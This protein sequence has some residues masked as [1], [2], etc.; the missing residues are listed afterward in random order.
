MPKNLYK[1]RNIFNK[2]IDDFIEEYPGIDNQ[3]FSGSNIK[4]I[5]YLPLLT[6]G[7]AAKKES[8]KIKVFGDLQTISISS[9][10]SVNPVRVFGNSAPIGWCKGA[11]TFA[12][13]M[14]FATINQGAFTDIYDVDLAESYI[15]G[16]TNMLPHYLPPFSIVLTVTNESGAACIRV[17]NNIIITNIGSVYSIDDLYVEEQYTFVATDSTPL[18]PVNQSQIQLPEIT[19]TV[20]RFGKN[21]STLVEESMNKAY[22]SILSLYENYKLYTDTE[23]K[24]SRI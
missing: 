15:N 14:V 21:V 7:S 13:T 2:R 1:N 5:M 12:G 8:S 24:R 4:A 9:T 16:S 17:I 18:I 23:N 11:I 20:S 19:S 3:V 10:R 6:L 22:G